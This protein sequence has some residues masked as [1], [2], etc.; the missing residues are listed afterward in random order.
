MTPRVWAC[1]VVVLLGSPAA[2]AAEPG[3]PRGGDDSLW[4]IAEVLSLPVIAREGSVAVRIRGAITMTH[5]RADVAVV[6]DDSG[7]L[8]LNFGSLA[9]GS[10][11]RRLL[12]PGCEGSGVIVTGML[13]RG[14]YS[15][16]LDVRRVTPAAAAMPEPLPADFER[17]FTGAD[18]G[19]LVACEGIVQ[20]CRQG[21]RQVRLV[22]ACQS[23]RLPVYLLSAGEVPDTDALLDARVRVE[24]VVGS[25]RNTRG[26]FLAPQLVCSGPDSFR[27]LAPPPSTPF[28]APLVPLAEL[29]RYRFEPVSANRITTEGVV[30]FVGRQ[31]LF[32]QEGMRGVR[33]RTTDQADVAVG[34]R[35]RVAGFIENSRRIAGIQGALVER[36]GPEQP[37][38]PILI[39]PDEVVRINT[40]AVQRHT[41]A[42]PSDG[43]GCLIRF[44][45]TVIEAKESEAGSEI[46]LSAGDSTVTARLARPGQGSQPGSESLAGLL[47]GSRVEARGVLEI[48]LLD[49]DGTLHVT[50]TPTLRQMSLHLREAADLTVLERPSWWTPRRLGI[51]L[52]GSLAVLAGAL[53]WV[54]LLRREVASHA[55][56]LAH[57]MRCRRDA[58]VEYAASTRERNRLAANLHD[59]LLQTLRGIDFQLGACRAYRDRPDGGRVDHLEV[60]RRMVN[61]ASE[62][63]RDSV[64]ALRTMPLAGRSFGESLE[65]LAR[66]LGHGRP[67]RITVTGEGRPFEL[68]QFVA[69]NLLLV[70]QEAIQNAVRHATAETIT[71][72]VS[73]DANGDEVT[74][75]V[76]DDGCGFTPGQQAGPDQGHFGIA[77]MRERA[78]RLGGSVALASAPAQG[79]SVTVRVGKRDYDEQ[80]DV[81]AEEPTSAAPRE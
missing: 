54:G 15:P 75:R 44:P 31:L 64:W 27:M 59:T 79:T 57:E 1:F 13:H 20:A 67:E 6:Q 68:P 19:L 8:W 45:A 72:V 14:G 62:E 60:A 11:D 24:G 51:L 9:E 25:V 77:G 43:D 38:E 4:P 73:F 30:T 32:L 21:D 7:G 16:S 55:R 46:V 28:E 53:V 26:E 12:R 3:D 70:A 80:F 18:N 49:D 40:R 36:V 47:P 65:Q 63:L 69:G 58:A 17:L 41:M 52:G 50:T 78:E 76:T 10:A 42:E 56:M 35:V 22:L 66:Q 71:V 81:A 39:R 34:D 29:G 2:A 74:V 33:V 5:P 23:R 61:H 37:P 48:Q